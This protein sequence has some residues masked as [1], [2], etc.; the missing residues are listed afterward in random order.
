M[1]RLLN[2]KSKEVGILFRIHWS[3][4]NAVGLHGGEEIDRRI[5]ILSYTRANESFL[6]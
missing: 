6:E 5:K 1:E 4:L 2:M 3:H